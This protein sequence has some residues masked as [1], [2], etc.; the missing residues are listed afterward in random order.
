MTSS[1]YNSPSALAHELKE[2]AAYYTPPLKLSIVQY[3]RFDAPDSPVWLLSEPYEVPA[4]HRAKIGIWPQQDGLFLQWCIEKG[5][6][7]A[8]AQNFAPQQQMDSTWAWMRWLATLENGSFAAQLQKAGQ[9]AEQPLMAV[10]RFSTATPRRQ[11]RYQG[12]EG[13]EEIWQPYKGHLVHESS[14]GERVHNAE[15]SQNLPL[16]DL[17][18]VLAQTPEYEWCWVDFGIGATLP[19]GAPTFAAEDIWQRF[20]EPW[21]AWL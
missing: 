10:L 9:Q 14:A 4:H 7:G 12:L 5:V 6:T 18:R 1:S 8:A 16:A 3:D 13:Q 2:V 17:G 21:V 15:L 19:L 20:V 11:G